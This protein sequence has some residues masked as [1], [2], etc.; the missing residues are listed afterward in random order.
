MNY[1]NTYKRKLVNSVNQ[2]SKHKLIF[3]FDTTE[4]YEFKILDKYGKQI[5]ISDQ[6][7]FYICGSTTAD[8]KNIIFF[9]EDFVVEND[10]LSFKINSNTKEYL[11]KVT[12]RNIHIYI[13]IAEIKDGVSTVLLMDEAEA[14]NRLY[15][16]GTPQ[17]LALEKYYTKSEIDNLFSSFDLDF[18]ES[19]PI[20]SADKK[21]I[22]FK[23]DK[24]NPADVQGSAINTNI[25]GWGDA[26]ISFNSNSLEDDLNVVINWMGNNEKSNAIKHE[27]FETRLKT[28]E[29]NSTT[30]EMPTISVNGFTANEN[31]EITL[32][33]T[34]DDIISNFYGNGD[35]LTT[36]LSNI[37][38]NM[39]QNVEQEFNNRNYIK[40]IDGLQ[41][42]ENGNVD[43]TGSYVYSINNS[44]YPDENGNVN[45]VVTS[46]N[47][48][49]PD[50]FGNVE[51]QGAIFYSVLGDFA[52]TIA[53]TSFQ[54]EY[55]WNVTES[56]YVSD[57][58]LEIMTRFD[59][60]QAANASRHEEFDTRLTTL[61][62]NTSSGT[63]NITVNNISPDES[64]NIV[65]TSDQIISNFY[66]NGDN[67]TTELSNIQN[68]MW[69]NV[70]QEFNNRNYVKTISGLSADE[71]GDVPSI[72]T[73]VNNIPASDQWGNL[74]LFSTDIQHHSPEQSVG[75]VLDE[76]TSKI[77]DIQS[78]LDAINGEVI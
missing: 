26:W 34:T 4:Y 73:T 5:K 13:E 64:G 21:D 55:I 32:E 38:N 16:S 29:N 3:D 65:L 70:E 31:G 20:Y 72:V 2:I 7:R 40:T 52:T 42:D 17:P 10:V 22:V 46:V 37:Q 76:L 49:A 41:A 60:D 48:T 45:G 69:Q 62:E 57:L 27:E 75:D 12:D 63:S 68:N 66:G 18:E 9:S 59:A 44:L 74:W 47:G 14:N 24:I 43:L 19:D 58:L 8:N 23:G 54:T 15:T 56:S 51:L 35:N 28:L 1:I 25:D 61:E 30:P 71:N 39:W 67:L 53:E 50:E 11:Q 6:S 36:E 78:V 77:G 33:L